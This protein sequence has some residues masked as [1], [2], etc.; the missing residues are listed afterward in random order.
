MWMPEITNYFVTF[1]WDMR[2]DMELAYPGLSDNAAKLC[3]CRTKLGR[4][5]ENNW[6][7]VHDIYVNA[8]QLFNFEGIDSSEISYQNIPTVLS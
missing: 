5:S 7:H 2:N 8:I 3:I 4:Y 1:K 6:V